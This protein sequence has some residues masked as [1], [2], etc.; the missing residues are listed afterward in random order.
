MHSRAYVPRSVYPGGAL[1]GD[2]AIFMISNLLVLQERLRAARAELRKL[3]PFSVAW[4]Q[5]A[6][7]VW[8]LEDALTTI[9]P[10]GSR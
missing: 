5:Q 6:R 7:V 2:T 4:N 1:A 10:K 8:A 3:E 9:P